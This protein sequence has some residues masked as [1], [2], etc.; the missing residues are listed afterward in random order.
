M[1]GTL[2]PGQHW[3]AALKKWMLLIM[4]SPTIKVVRKN[5][6]Q[7]G[8][9]R[10]QKLMVVGSRR[11]PEHGLHPHFVWKLSLRSL[12]EG[13]CPGRWV[14][15]L[16]LLFPQQLTLTPPRKVSTLKADVSLIKLQKKKKTFSKVSAVSLPC[17]PKGDSSMCCSAAPDRV[18]S[19][20]WKQQKH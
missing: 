9:K 15:W 3:V 11:G 19:L 7:R 5:R 17:G 16:D 20:H 1:S 10:K 18:L 12:S 4:E 13:R 6:G 8:E 14:L 2:A